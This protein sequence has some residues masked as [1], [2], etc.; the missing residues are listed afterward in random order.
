[1]HADRSD[2]CYVA[3]QKQK[4]I[5]SGGLSNATKMTIEIIKFTHNKRQLWYGYFVNETISWMR[6]IILK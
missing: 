2:R 6:A 3:K 1:M 4:K 5:I